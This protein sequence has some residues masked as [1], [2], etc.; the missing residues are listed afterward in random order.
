MSSEPQEFQVDLVDWCREQRATALKNIEIIDRGNFQMGDARRQMSKDHTSALRATYERIF[1][2][3]G[4]L[5][6]ECGGF[7]TYAP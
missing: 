6:K 1:E 2:Q 7:D 3:M 5:L 4:L